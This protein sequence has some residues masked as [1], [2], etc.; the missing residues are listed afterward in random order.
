[1]KLLNILFITLMG[2]LILTWPLAASS[3]AKFI[4]IGK[5]RYIN[6]NYI[7]YMQDTQGGCEIM[8]DS[9]KPPAMSTYYFEVSCRDFVKHYG[10]EII[11]STFS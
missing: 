11:S 10:L 5:E 6:I 2:Q 7:I 8:I 1:M 4:D 3:L 9:S